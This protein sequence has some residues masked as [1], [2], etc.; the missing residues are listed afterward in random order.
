M[1]SLTDAKTTLF[2]HQNAPPK[3]LLSFLHKNTKKEQCLAPLMRTTRPCVP[4]FNQLR[5][6]FSKRDLKEQSVRHLN[7]VSLP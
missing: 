6:H 1:P 5:R 3:K 2:Q 4:F 7:S